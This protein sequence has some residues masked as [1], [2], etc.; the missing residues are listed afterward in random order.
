M[1][2]SG[3]LNT[4]KVGSSSRKIRSFS[5]YEKSDEV[6][7][8]DQSHIV[9]VH[10]GQLRVQ[11]GDCTI[12]VAAE[13]GVFLS[14][15][16]YL[17]EYSPLDGAYKASIIT[18]DNELVSQLLQKHSD[19][20]MMLPKVDKVCSGLFTFG[21]NILVEQ[22]LSSMQ[23]LEQQAYPDAIMCLK[24]EELLILLLHGKGGESLYALLSQQT[25]RTSERLRRFMEQHYLKEWK[26]TD[27]AQ[28]FGASLTTFKELFNEHY[29]ISPRAWISERRLLHAHKLLLTSK[30]SIVDVAMEAGFSSQS[31]FTQSYRRRFGTTPSRV[32]SGDDQVAIAK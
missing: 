30:M 26:L 29:G 8:S 25:N 13:N 6:F 11:T 12:D 23:T 14:Q 17:F 28:E 24:Y 22:V 15:G 27:Y 19:L 10:N 31:Y 16:D 5:R 9:V 3:Q 32:R 18:Y 4:E 21:L 7:H 20:L 1:D 2:V